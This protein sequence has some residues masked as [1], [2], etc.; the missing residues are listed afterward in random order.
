MNIQKKLAH[1]V[2]SRPL[3]PSCS[4]TIITAYNT[5]TVGD[6]G[7]GILRVFERILFSVHKELFG[8]TSGPENSEFV[9]FRDSL[10]KNINTELSHSKIDLLIVGKKMPYNPLKE[11]SQFLIEIIYLQRMINKSAPNSCLCFWE[12]HLIVGS[13][14]CNLV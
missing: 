8:N 11:S 7:A 3:S 14:G 2:K 6:T 4:F 13:F 9:Q 10:W 1:L 5:Y 12:K